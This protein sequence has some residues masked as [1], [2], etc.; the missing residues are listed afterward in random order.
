MQIGY[1]TSDT[2][3]NVKC[4]PIK[5]F[6]AWMQ[7]DN[8][9]VNKWPGKIT[10]SSDFYE[11]L[12]EHAVPLDPR[13]IAALQN[14]ALA[15]DCYTWLANRLCRVKERGGVTLSWK[16]LREQF[17]QEYGCEKDFKREFLNSLRKAHAVYPDAKI[18]QV[19][20]GLRLVPSPPPIK[21]RQV[22]VALPASGR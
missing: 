6:E 17:G 2:V 21:R 11:T 5:Q 14:S 4:D 15:L 7:N 13:A 18:E 12:T 16:N 20:G 10:L 3:V 19:N 1:R 22:V 9:T 8:G